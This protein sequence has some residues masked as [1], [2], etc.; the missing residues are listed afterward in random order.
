[1]I[2]YRYTEIEIKH[3]SYV[4]IELLD[5]NQ[6][7][8][9]NIFDTINYNNSSFRGKSIIMHDEKVIPGPTTFYGVIGP[10]REFLKSKENI[11]SLIWRGPFTL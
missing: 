10:L 1:M 4:F 11:E 6:D 2:I 5:Y 3:E 9:V 8:D 7:N